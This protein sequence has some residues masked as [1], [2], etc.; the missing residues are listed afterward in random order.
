MILA[1]FHW[2]SLHQLGVGEMWVRTGVG[3][4]TRLLPVHVIH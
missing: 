4:S 1:L 2:P 3:D